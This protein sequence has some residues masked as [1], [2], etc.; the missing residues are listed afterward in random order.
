LADLYKNAVVKEIA[1]FSGS[2]MTQEVN[3]IYFGGGTP[4]LVPAEHLAEIL[5]ECRRR[6][7]VM[8][9]CEVSMEANPGTISS[10]KLTIYRR[11]GINRVSL[12][13]Q[14][15]DNGE[16]SSIGRLHSASM[17]PESFDQLRDSGFTNINLDLMLGLPQQTRVSWKRTLGEAA[18]LS[19][20]HIS[21]YMLD[22]DERC[23]LSS[24]A[25]GGLIDL[26][27][28]DLVS[29]LYLE[30]ISFLTSCGYLQYEISNFA[31][32]GFACRHNL[33][34]WKREAVLG[35]GVGSHSFDLKSR[36]ANCSGIEDYLSLM[37]KSAGP[38]S[39]REQVSDEQALQETFF[40][41]LRLTEGIDCSR[42]RNGSHENY[43]KKYEESLKDLQSRG[44]I[45]RRDS[46]IRL[47]QTGMLLS[48]E[49]FQ[50]F[51]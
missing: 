32:P 19:A 46:I 49:I 8:E 9:D 10:E 37:E 4:S 6:F 17:I 23:Q 30:T 41:G 38:V 11:A 33:K 29:D 14:S 13:A 2:L 26:P 1:S 31:K 34:Y 12:G 28:E 47:T 48:N 43:L 18:R 24:L 3:S 5:S 39:W 20:P 15:F 36:Y 42:L 22:L 7:F 50:L 25:A 40:L 44:L 27:G 51:V 35:F 21:V 16:L 45:E